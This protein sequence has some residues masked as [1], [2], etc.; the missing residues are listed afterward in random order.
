M[1]YIV[2]GITAL[3][4]LSGLVIY[5][6][7]FNAKHREIFAE[8]TEFTISADDLQF[9]FADNQKVATKKYMNKV[10]ETYGLVTEVDD[11]TLVLENKIQVYFLSELKQEI[12]VGDN[13]SIK[14]RCVGFDE[15]L[16]T[17][18]MDQATTIKTN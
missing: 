4:L 14:G 18:K 3:I 17:V 5:E 10:I 6:K 15:L 7:V 11:N 12:T 13:L 9:H 16:L 2:I 1:K 8:P